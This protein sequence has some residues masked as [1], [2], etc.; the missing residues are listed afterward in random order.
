MAEAMRS[1]VWDRQAATPHPTLKGLSDRRRPQWAGGGANTKEDLA[2]CQIGPSIAKVVNNTRADL[3]G[4]REEQWCL[5]LGARDVQL[6][7]APVDEVLP[8]VVD[9][10][11]EKAAYPS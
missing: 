5:G 3:L 7:R 11:I 8:K 6:L 4:Q 10:G 1:L 9:L 2:V